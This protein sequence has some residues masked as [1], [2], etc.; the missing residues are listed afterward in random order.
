[1]NRFRFDLL[2]PSIQNLTDSITSLL[3]IGLWG[4]ATG[5]GWSQ[6]TP[7][8]YLSQGVELVGYCNMQD[9][10]AFKLSIKEHRGR[11]YLFTGH[12]WH[13]GWSVVDVT[14]PAKPFVA[15]FI[16]GPPNTWTLQ[17]ELSGNRMVTALEKIFPNFG[18]N[19]GPFQEGVYIWDISDPLNPVRQGQFK[20]GGTGTHRNWYAGGR[21]MHLA[22]NMKGYLGNIYVIVDISNP[23]KPVEAG[24]WWVKGQH[25]ARGEEPNEP[26]ISL[27]GPPYIVGNTAYLP[28]GSAGLIILDISNVSKPRQ[29]GRLDFSPPFHQQFGIHTVIPVPGKNLAYVN[30]EDVS[31]GRGPIHHASIVDISDLKN[32]KLLSVLPRPIPPKGVGYDDFNLRG[33]WSGPHNVNTLLH[34]PD[35]QPQ[36]SLLYMT[37]F[38]AGLRIYNVKN[39]RLPVEVA[40][41]L[42]P[43]PQKRYG[44][45]PQ[46]ELVVQTEDV[47]VDRRG[48]I[49]ITDKNQGVYILRIK[50]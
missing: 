30:S 6:T 1:M 26:H 23:H 14:D 27:H 38:N 11:W 2:N 32:P 3:S 8:G 25:Q 42:P 5:C 10:P 19:N 39:P 24:R 35:V 41:F 20:T 46:G 47:L 36:D 12:F 17:M 15:K 49:Y 18:G 4:L 43:D 22:A 33:G 50:P 45:M 40:W 9:R 37:Y 44:P 16:D 13:S 34:N 28:Y 31:Y 21:Y 7:T 29:V 48:Y